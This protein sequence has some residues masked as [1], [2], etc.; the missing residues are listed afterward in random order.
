LSGVHKSRIIDTGD[1]SKSTVLFV[2]KIVNLSGWLTLP[3]N[4]LSLLCCGVGNVACII[5]VPLDVNNKKVLSAVLM[6]GVV[7]PVAPLY[8]TFLT[9]GN[10]ALAPV[11]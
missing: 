2:F 4:I 1:T 10:V 9:S 6:Y 7:K 8:M 5:R 3:K 11:L